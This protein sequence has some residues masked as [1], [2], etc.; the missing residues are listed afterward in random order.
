[1]YINR[2]LKRKSTTK[3]LQ[4]KFYGQKIYSYSKKIYITCSTA[5]KVK[6]TVFTN[7]IRKHFS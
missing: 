3:I 1:M 6:A 7:N 2:A 4:P 5:K